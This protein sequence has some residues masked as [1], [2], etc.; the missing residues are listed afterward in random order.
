MTWQALVQGRFHPISDLC[1][2]PVGSTGSF[3]HN[4]KSQGESVA[5]NGCNF[6]ASDTLYG[7]LRAKS[8]PE[9]VAQDQPDALAS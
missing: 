6:T 1:S 5:T 2:C 8:Y 7:H 4:N 9:H 3:E